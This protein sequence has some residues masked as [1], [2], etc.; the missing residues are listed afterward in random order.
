MRQEELSPLRKT[1]AN[2]HAKLAPGDSVGAIGLRHFR[3]ILICF[4]D[5][6]LR[7]AAADGCL[8]VAAA[9]SATDWRATVDEDGQYSFAIAL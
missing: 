3:D 1:C 7:A 2:P 4:C 6:L 9:C 8:E 5:G